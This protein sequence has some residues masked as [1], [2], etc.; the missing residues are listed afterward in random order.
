VKLYRYHPIDGRDA[1]DFSSELRTA[2]AEQKQ[3]LAS[4]I[5]HG[6]RFYWNQTGDSGVWERVER[7]N[8][9]FVLKVT[10]R[11]YEFVDTR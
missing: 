6:A 10:G 7:A 3:E 5:R 9:E 4:M 11:P 2:T 8:I 1:E